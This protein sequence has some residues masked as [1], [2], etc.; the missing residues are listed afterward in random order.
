MRSPYY[1]YL[2]FAII[3][4]AITLI[5]NALHQNNEPAKEYLQKVNTN[6][7]LEVGKAESAMTQLKKQ[8]LD[9]KNLNFGELLQANTYPVF[10]YQN[11]ELKFWT[12]NRFK[13]ESESILGKFSQISIENNHG[14]FIVL[15]DSAIL[16]ENRYQ[17]AMVVPLFVKARDNQYVKASLNQDIFLTNDIRI[18]LEQDEGY[19]IKSK[20]GRTLFT[21]ALPISP[22][23]L[24][25][26]S[27][28]FY[29]S[30]ISFFSLLTLLFT[31]LQ[32]RLNL[33]EFLRQEKVLAGFIMLSFSVFSIRLMMLFFDIPVGLKQFDLFGIK[34]YS[35]SFVTPSLGDLLLNM[36][37]LSILGG[38]IYLNYHVLLPIKKL[39][40]CPQWLRKIISVIL[41]L[42]TYL[43]F[44]FL[45][46]NLESIYF[47]SQTS[48]D[49]TSDINFNTFKVACF[50]IFLLSALLYFFTSHVVSRLLFFLNSSPKQ[51]LILIII[52]SLIFIPTTIFLSVPDMLIFMLNFLYLAVISLV[53]LP[54]N[55]KK[56]GYT[57]YLYLCFSTIVAA[58]LGSY[59]IYTFEKTMDSLNKNLF[60]NQLL[61]ENDKHGEFLLNNV[62]KEI[63]Q[64]QM[65]KTRM[66]AV[67]SKDLIIQK[68][69]RYHLSSYFDKYD[70]NVLL[71]NDLGEPY[72]YDQ[73]YDSMFTKFHLDKYKTD[74]KD[75]YFVQD[76]TGNTKRYLVFMEIARKDQQIGKIV[77]DLRLKKILPN[78]IYP[79]LFL[80]KRFA[81]IYDDSDVSYAIYRNNLLSYT[82]GDFNYEKKFLKLFISD[83]N[84]ILE[85]EIFWKDHR[86]LLIE[87]DN[88]RYVVISSAFSPMQSL[89]SNFSFLFIILFVFKLF[90]ATLYYFYVQKVSFQLNFSARIQLYLKTSK[91]RILGK[92]K[93]LAEIL[94]SNW[95]V[96]TK[97]CEVLK[98]CS[99]R[100]FKPADSR[101]RTSICLI[102]T[103]FYWFLANLLF[104]KVICLPNSSTQMQWKAL[105]K[106]GKTKLCSPNLW[107]NS[108]TNR[109]IWA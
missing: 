38:F 1:F 19:P 66:V 85:R 37:V 8:L 28:G 51:I 15:K 81:N 88:N 41:V 23:V 33:K 98:N 68:I 12:D 45:F 90:M 7:Q 97:V 40:A 34:F 53:K 93:A 75:I 13:I 50:F 80:D 29:H 92:P 55:V 84:E 89:L 27:V 52:A 86:H 82:Y 103:A 11:D 10:I 42:F 49:I 5:L 44:Y 104:T 48:L 16:G 20:E 74:Y 94:L 17:M 83:K 79:N 99:K 96:F 46:A 65:I 32:I 107:G 39:L 87:G 47:S 77:L 95:K 62:I 18:S 30:A 106:K 31:F 91:I 9:K 108:T 61:I 14:I 36:I 76:L 71:F 105:T 56:L 101:K 57:T 64:D 2:P 21:I 24:Q 59:S 100:S 109:C 54:K 69:K 35:S 78:S 25:A 72:N 6:L 102:K 73:S 67:L 58:M 22:Q 63:K 60:A 70:L 3:C 4:L 43:A 26:V